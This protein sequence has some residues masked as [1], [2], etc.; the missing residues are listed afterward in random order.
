[1]CTSNFRLSNT[2]YTADKLL[3]STAKGGKLGTVRR[4]VPILDS[5]AKTMQEQAQIQQDH[6]QIQSDR[7]PL[8]AALRKHFSSFKGLTA[9]RPSELEEFF[10][11]DEDTTIYKD[12]ANGN[13]F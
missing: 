4:G 9:P 3:T 11:D 12:T 10:T 13:G 6:A 2:M 7:S 1:M 5:I 8:R